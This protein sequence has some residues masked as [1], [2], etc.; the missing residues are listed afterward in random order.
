MAPDTKKPGACA[1]A[2]PG[3]GE[4]RLTFA[5]PERP[6][7]RT[8]CRCPSSRHPRR[9][10]AAWP[11]RPDGRNGPRAVAARWRRRSSGQRDP[12]SRPSFHP[13]PDPRRAC[14]AQLN[15]PTLPDTARLCAN[16]TRA[17]DGRRTKEGRRSGD[18]P[19]VPPTHP[20]ESLPVGWGY[21]VAAPAR[22]A[23][24]LPNR[25]VTSLPMPMPRHVAQGAAAGFRR[26]Q[27]R[28]SMSVRAT[29][30]SSRTSDAMVVSTATAGK[31]GA[32]KS[33]FGV[34][35]MQHT[36][37]DGSARRADPRAGA[38]G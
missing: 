2:G 18:L 38:I 17:L 27:S 15:C 23:S 1:A 24:E 31:G 8:G 4:A 37:I 21:R 28:V 16:A 9:R 19:T 12:C 36:T 11:K 32:I 26:W 3:L 13:A 14:G 10:Q 29:G 33:A 35:K 20:A 34:G 30:R 25:R 6:A 7:G 22:C 5:P